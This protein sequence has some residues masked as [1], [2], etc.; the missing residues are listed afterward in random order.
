MSSCFLIQFCSLP[1]ATSYRVSNSHI[2]TTIFQSNNRLFIKT[3]KQIK[4]NPKS[5]VINENKNYINVQLTANDDTNVNI[6]LRRSIRKKSE[7]NNKN[8]NDHDMEDD[9]V[10][11]NNIMDNVDSID[12]ISNQVLKNYLLSLESNDIFLFIKDNDFINMYADLL[13]SILFFIQLRNDLTNLNPYVNKLVHNFVVKNDIYL[14]SAYRALMPITTLSNRNNILPDIPKIK[15]LCH[16]VVIN[17]I[18][19]II[20]DTIIIE[21]NSCENDNRPKNK[22][23]IEQSMENR[24][25]E[26]ELLNSPDNKMSTP[27]AC[28]IGMLQRMIVVSP[29]KAPIRSVILSSIDNIIKALINLTNDNN[30]NNNNNSSHRLIARWGQRWGPRA[31]VSFVFLFYGRRYLHSFPSNASPIWVGD[32]HKYHVIVTSMM[33]LFFDSV[34]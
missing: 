25:C 7:D 23:T 20:N 10:E 14:I 11:D 29:D 15:N 26:N 30:N 31:L 28:I 21:S 3:I 1:G 34:Y 24:S 27:L 4:T 22:M 8:F 6:N 13:V 5:K 17:I 2:I 16:K 32:Y 9:N 33:G 12:I 19:N 18:I